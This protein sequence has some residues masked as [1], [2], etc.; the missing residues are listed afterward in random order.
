LSCFVP[1]VLSQNTIQISGNKTKVADHWVDSVLNSLSLNKKIAQLLSVRAYSNKG[2]EHQKAIM[3][4]IRK[5]GIGGLTFFQGGPLRQ[6]V[7]ANIY[8]SQS[9]VP[10][11]ISLDAEWGLGMRLDSTISFPYQ[12]TL[13][14]MNSDTLVYA[15]ASE[16]SRQ[17]RRLGVHMNL[18]PVVDINN[19]PHNPVIN[20]RS[21]GE[22][23]TNVAAKGLAYM[24]GMQD[25]GV[26]ATAKHF[27]GHGDTDSDSHY[28]LP[29]IRHSKSRLDTLEL[30]PFKQLI[31]EGTAGVMMAHLF[32]PAYDTTRNLASSLSQPIVTGLLRENMGFKGL[33]VTDALD[34]QGV[35]NYFKPG[36]IELQAFMAGND[37][38]LLPQ[39][40]P[41]TIKSIK[42]AVRNGHIKEYDITSRCRKVLTFKYLAGLANYKPV[43]IQGLTEDLNNARS[44][45]IIREIYK[46]AV[47]LVRNT[48][49]MI[50]L[51]DTDSLNMASLSLGSQ[52]ITPFQVMLSNFAHVQHFCHSFQGIDKY[53]DSIT[54][55]FEPF[56]LVIISLHNLT[57]NPDKDFGISTQLVSFIDQIREKKHVILDIFGSPYVLSQFTDIKN[58]D[59]LLVSYQNSVDAQEVSA[60]IIFG[61]LA[62]RGK[63]PVTGSNEF[64]VNTGI[65]TVSNS[66]LTYVVPG[67]IGIKSEELLYID[68]LVLQCIADSVFPG[69]QI[70][71]A[72]DGKVFYQNSFG[73]HTYD[74]FDPVKNT[75]LYD[76]AS[77]TKIV[78]TTLAVMKLKEEGKIDLDMK[79]GDYLPFARGTNKADLTIREI[80][81]H[82]AQLKPWIPFYKNVLHNGFP[83]TAIFSK[84]YSTSFPYRVAENLFIHR[85]YPWKM[86]DT[87]MTSPLIV[88]KEYIYSD[89]GFYLLKR[90][91]ENVAN[92]PFDSYVEENFY[93]P[94]G[95]YTMCFRPRDH[96]ELTDIVPTEIDTVFRHQLIHGD[97]HDPGAAMFGGVSGHAGL[98]SD[99]NDLLIIM[100]MLLQY[101]QYNG[102]RYLDSVTVV[103]FT[104]QQFPNNRNRRGLGFDKPD[105][106]ADNHGPACGSASSQSFGHSGFTGT[107]AWADPENKLVYVF[108]SNRVYPTALNNKLIER[109]I[110]TKIQQVFYD[111]LKKA[112][113]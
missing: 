66:R 36:E 51:D 33:V 69:C 80:M 112:H 109:N 27:P 20:Y 110:R 30:E 102:Q 62:A 90:I 56:N 107:Y 9:Q 111:L 45:T 94:L 75:D 29:V 105:T 99:A 63:L 87:I 83:D 85:D 70:M 96:F 7:L 21:F 18:A 91:I 26:L 95:L 79:V 31:N 52:S 92:R 59:G 108:L 106:L 4:L 39:D 5:F 60:Q 15:M 28:T 3:E 12:M 6:A 67:E 81:A 57:N 34:M 25:N 41:T 50:P 14:A 61:S 104:K 48:N 113:K 13:G 24:H 42:Q 40:V 19:N 86:Y 46:S 38:L 44:K 58:I 65:V 101:G 55:L 54:E 74:K 8:Q 71:A 22:D 53:S 37:I 17:C 100:Q 32:L 76:L 84:I 93:K 49:N 103:E 43:I 11:L 72:V 64:P 10:L 98:F 89:L 82:Q 2:P 23:K 97:V 35:T 88:K 47:T 78:A 68:T 16:I 77:V 73:Y 1:A